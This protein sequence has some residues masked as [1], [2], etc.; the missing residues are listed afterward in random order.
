MTRKVDFMEV[1]CEISRNYIERYSVGH[2]SELDMKTA[3][4]EY[5][6]RTVRETMCS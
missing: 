1:S 2:D 4:I 3:F 5:F 6:L